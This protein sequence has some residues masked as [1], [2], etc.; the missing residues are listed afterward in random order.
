MDDDL[1]G[2]GLALA[3]ALAIVPDTLLM[4]L[5]GLGAGQMVAW[6]GLLM[7]GVLLA[8]W[9]LRSPGRQAD[10]RHVATPAGAGAVAAQAVNA[11]LF[12]FGIATAPVSV[13]LFAVATV[14]IWSALMGALFLD[15]RAGRTTLAASAMVLAGIGISVSGGGHG[16]TGG[17]TLGA[18]SGLCVAFAL[19]SSF[20]LYRANP[21]LPV[22][23]TV[24]TGALIAGCIGWSVA[25]P[26]TETRGWLPAIW[27]TGLV[28]L[29]V[30]FTTLGIASRYTVAANVSLLLLLETVLGPVAVWIA[31]GEAVGIA[32]L[33]GGGIVIATLAAYLWDQRRRALPPRAAYSS[34]GPI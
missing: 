26:L 27:V 28:I 31:L 23:L 25:A 32:G 12:S 34:A 15:D 5:S 20:T 9:G 33:V 16:S 18:L 19:A 30:S 24:G 22:F 10:L 8:L 4:R 11:G 6:R 7:A 3:G 17:A 2:I 13:V 1:K 29:P 14:P 21:R